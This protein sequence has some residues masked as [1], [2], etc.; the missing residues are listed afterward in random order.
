MKRGC[1][2]A[3]AIVMINLDVAGFAPLRSCR[4]D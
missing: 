3:V 2:K 4:R 1:E